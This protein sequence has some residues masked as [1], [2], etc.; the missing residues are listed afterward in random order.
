MREDAVARRTIQERLAQLEAQ[1]KTQAH[2]ERSRG[3]TPNPRRSGAR[4]GRKGALTSCCAS[5]AAR[6]A[7]DWLHREM[8]DRQT[9]RLRTSLT[10]SRAE[11]ENERD[12][13]THDYTRRAGIAHAEI[14]LP[15][16]SR[17]D[18]A[19]RPEARLIGFIERW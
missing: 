11:L 18:W 4:K 3:R 8:V 16:G 17:A 1:K 5:A 10:L 9:A 12:G 2:L 6:G 13:L 19:L 7:T 15:Q 14:V